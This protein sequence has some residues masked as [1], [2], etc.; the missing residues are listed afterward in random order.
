[1]IG[2]S[3]FL[4]NRRKKGSRLAYDGIIID[5]QEF[6]LTGYTTYGRMWQM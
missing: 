3:F 4:S 2:D 1:M 6:F 5:E